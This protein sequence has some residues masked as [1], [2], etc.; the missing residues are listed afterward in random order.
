MFIN[1]PN[2]LNDSAS[3]CQLLP[4]NRASC[5]Q[6][7]LV[8]ATWKLNSRSLSNWQQVSTPRV[9]KQHLAATSGGVFSHA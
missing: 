3:C 8:G 7:L 4:R 6:L 5:C 9:R 2:I 1:L